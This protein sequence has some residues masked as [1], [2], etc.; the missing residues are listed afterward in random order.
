VIRASRALSRSDRSDHPAP[1]P[2]A[3]ADFMLRAWDGAVLDP[4]MGGGTTLVAAYRLNRTAIGIEIDEKYC[5]I[6][7]KRL[8]QEV[9]PL[10]AAV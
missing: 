7:A 9:L 5:E 6:A 3:F 1:Y 8:E 10:E 2:V 4:F